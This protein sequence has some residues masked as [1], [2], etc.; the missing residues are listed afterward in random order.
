[1]LSVK[2]SQVVTQMYSNVQHEDKETNEKEKDK[3]K[4]RHQFLTSSSS[5]MTLP[6][7]L[8]PQASADAQH[9][10]TAS[11]EFENPPLNK[12]V[13]SEGLN[14]TLRCNSSSAVLNRLVDSS[15]VI[16][17]FAQAFY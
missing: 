13:L 15:S 12:A 11:N 10:V 17:L 7:I 4:D 8:S 9:A 14:S 16:L 5:T 6:P 3:A 1:M 2:L